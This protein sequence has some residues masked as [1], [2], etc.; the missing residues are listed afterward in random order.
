M[1]IDNYVK[2]K[3]LTSHDRYLFD[4]KH[5]APAGFQ[6]RDVIRFLAVDIILVLCLKLLL[7]LGVF[8]TVNIYIISILASKLLLLC[9]LL[10]LVKARPDGW[11]AAGARSLG[12][13]WSWPLALAIYAA[14]YPGLLW[15]SRAN[16]E[17]MALLYGLAGW[18]YVPQAQDVVAL[19]FNDS[20]VIAGS[21]RLVLVVFAVIIGPWMEELAFRGVGL[22]G[23]R[24][25]GGL[26]GAVIWAGILFGIYH[27]SFNL[28]LPL[29]ALGIL[30]GVVRSIS[31]SLWCCTFYHCLH[32]ALA[33]GIT[34]YE[35]GWLENY[36]SFF[37]FS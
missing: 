34:A 27:F 25:G 7:N 3:A 11:R 8:P 10:W 19:I 17:I 9:Y 4:S 24:K 15:L 18:H 37:N 1:Q 2:E 35:L 16:E 23:F 12:R 33:L 13:W 31:G 28:L 32:N 14:A 22:D 36:R 26:F 5:A 6:S 20:G 21:L 30:F 29:S